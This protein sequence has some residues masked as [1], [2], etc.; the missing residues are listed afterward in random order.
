M[1]K[2]PGAASLGSASISDCAL[3]RNQ[4]E[5]CRNNSFLTERGACPMSQVKTRPCKTCGRPYYYSDIVDT[6]DKLRGLSPPE[7]CPKCVK[8]NRRD[9]NAV[10]AAYWRAPVE[11]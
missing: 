4:Q 9:I 6:S 3:S 1:T 7:R 8:E 11:T 2:H 5:P 10:G